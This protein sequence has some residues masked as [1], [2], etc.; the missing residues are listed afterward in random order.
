MKDSAYKD[1]NKKGEKNGDKNWRIN[2]TKLT[3]YYLK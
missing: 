3:V 1:L 2:S